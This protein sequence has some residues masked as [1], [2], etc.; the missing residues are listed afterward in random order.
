MAESL[1]C[2]SLHQLSACSVKDEI[3]RCN[4]SKQHH[5]AGAR[6]IL[7]LDGHRQAADTRP[8]VNTVTNEGRDG[9]THRRALVFFSCWLNM[10]KDTQEKSRPK[11]RRATP[12]CWRRH[13]RIVKLSRSVVGFWK[14]CQI[15]RHNDGRDTGC[16]I[17]DRLNI[18]T[19]ER[20]ACL[21]N[22]CWLCEPLHKGGAES[23]VKVLSLS[24]G[25]ST[26]LRISGLSGTPIILRTWPEE[27]GHGGATAPV[28]DVTLSSRY[29]KLARDDQ[30]NS[31]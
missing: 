22:A 28:R 13:L 23:H 25:R 11:L 5:A 16:I 7:H 15:S 6:H 2:L 30:Q 1:L 21:C 14:V 29:H 19:R 10:T 9:K 12:G 18:Y 8:R 24:L 31:S 3:T 27:L 17:N 20:R 26:S 4:G